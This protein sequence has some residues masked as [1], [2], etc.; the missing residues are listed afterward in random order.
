VTLFY[1]FKTQHPLQLYSHFVLTYFLQ[2]QWGD[3][4]EGFTRVYFGAVG[5]RRK[6]A[7]FL[8]QIFA[9]LFSCTIL[10]NFCNIMA[11]QNKNHF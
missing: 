11:A 10:K 8:L 6:V 1:H 3:V 5:L 7:N 4:R 9:L 2:K